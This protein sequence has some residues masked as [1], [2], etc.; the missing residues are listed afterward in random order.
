MQ[1]D[2][3]GTSF[4][5]DF[6]CDLGGCLVRIKAG[7][8]P[9]FF[10]C[11]CEVDHDREERL[12]V[13][14]AH[15]S[16][17]NVW[18]NAARARSARS[19]NNR[20]SPR[21]PTPWHHPIPEPFPRSLLIIVAQSEKRFQRQVLHQLEWLWCWSAWRRWWSCRESLRTPPFRPRRSA[22]RTLCAQPIPPPQTHATKPPLPSP[23][24]F[25]QSRE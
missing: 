22:A 23:T 19:A 3:D 1:K 7:C 17:R 12:F 20:L 11:I 24:S 5:N 18:Q 15:S 14:A 21:A 2:G 10:V 8:A 6:V 16:R 9:E 13:C 4:G 25:P